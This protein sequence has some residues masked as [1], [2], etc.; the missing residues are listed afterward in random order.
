[1]PLFSR[2]VLGFLVVANANYLA[3]QQRRPVVRKGTVEVVVAIVGEEMQIRPIPLL[4]LEVWRGTDTARTSVRTGL[5]GHAT[6]TL[7][8]GDYHIRSAQTPSIAGR[9]YQWV[10]DVHVIADKVTHVELTNAN[11]QVDSTIV[12]TVTTARSIA[13][14]IALYDRLKSGVLQVRADLSSGTGFMIDTLDGVVI[15]NAHV[16]GNAEQVSVVLQTGT[17]VPAVVLA[18]NNDAD[19]AVLRI[20]TA[21]CPGCTRLHIARADPSGQVVV[22]GERVVAIGFPL[23]QRSTVTAGIVSTLRER[24]VISDVNI[25][26]GNSG[27]PLVNLQGEVVAI[28]TFGLASEKGG[29]GLGGSILLIRLLPI[30]DSARAASLRHPAPTLERLPMLDTAVYALTA[31]RSIADTASFDAYMKFGELR[32]GDFVISTST[33][34]SKL[35]AY[36]QY[37]ETVARDRRKR[38]ARAGLSEDQL[39]SQFGEF[40]NWM[41]YVGNLLAPAVTIEVSPRAGETSGSSWGRVLSAMAG[42]PSGRAK[43][44]Y[45]GDVQAVHWYRNGEPLVPVAGGRT[46]QVAFENNAWVVMNDVAYRGMYVFSP[47]AFAP[48]SNGAPPSIVLQIDDL[49][50]YDRFILRELP[51]DLVARVWNDFQPYFASNHPEKRFIAADPDRFESDF[52]ERCNKS[53]L[54]SGFESLNRTSR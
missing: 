18:K 33:T 9:R 40:H 11:A 46:P 50:H 38:E 47:E 5:D 43:F 29:P 31:M 49:K 48:D 12:A 30:L 8:T 53:P 22:P 13:P 2:A 10:T 45:K 1:M 24:A 14:E 17:R 23:F 27:G 15:T 6:M 51:P 34:L 35:V 41:E 36:R 32:F 3:G 19:V 21:A 42:T 16:V 25:N 44:E 28:N 37:Q 4:S 7:P 20:P 54:C 39:Y 26:E 52:S